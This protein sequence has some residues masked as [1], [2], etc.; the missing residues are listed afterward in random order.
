MLAFYTPSH[1]AGVLLFIAV[2]LGLAWQVGRWRASERAL[3]MTRDRAAQKTAE[4]RALI[5]AVPAAVFVT[6]HPGRP[7][8]R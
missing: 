5:D 6:R 3:R 2:S 1:A 8:V 7:A 4:L